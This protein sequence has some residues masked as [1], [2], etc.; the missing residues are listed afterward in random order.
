M[1]TRHTYGA[2]GGQKRTEDP[3]KL[4]IEIFGA[5]KWVMEYKPGFSE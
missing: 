4:E 2:Q 3:L 5:F 1:Y